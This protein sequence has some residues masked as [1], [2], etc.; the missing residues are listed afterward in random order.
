[1]IKIPENLVALAIKAQDETVGNEYRQMKAVVEIVISFLGEHH[2]C[3]ECAMYEDT[4]GQDITC[5]LCGLDPVADKIRKAFA[6]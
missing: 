3:P 2:I 6:K 5:A 4:G 1:M